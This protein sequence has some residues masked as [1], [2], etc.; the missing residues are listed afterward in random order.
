MALLKTEKRPSV[1][2]AKIS[3]RCEAVISTWLSRYEQEGITGLQT[4][5]GRGRM[6]R[7]SAQNTVHLQKAK[8]EIAN[9]QQSVKT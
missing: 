4:R 8:A 1:E 5:A 3:G 9:H 6:L 7:L 2:I